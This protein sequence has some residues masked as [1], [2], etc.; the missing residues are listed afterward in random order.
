MEVRQPVQDNVGISAYVA[1]CE[2]RNFVCV[3]LVVRT[4]TFQT[5]QTTYSSRRFQPLGVENSRSLV[6]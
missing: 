6:R 5:K 4:H 3:G 2:R 1:R